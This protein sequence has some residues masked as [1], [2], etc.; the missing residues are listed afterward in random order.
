MKEYKC[1]SRVFLGSPCQY[2][3][4]VKSEFEPR[5]CLKGAVHEEWEEVSCKESLF[6]SSEDVTLLNN[7]KYCECQEGPR[8]RTVTADFEHQICD[9][10]GNI[11]K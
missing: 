3:C 10:C 4:Q 2:S 11:S 7:V 9:R 5:G 1:K 8:G 6:G